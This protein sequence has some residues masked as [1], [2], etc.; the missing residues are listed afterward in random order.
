MH[1][2]GNGL[3]VD[4]VANPTIAENRDRPDGRGLFLMRNYM[5]LVEHN[6]HG[7]IVTLV[8]FRTGE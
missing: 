7:N 4:Q 2:K 5:D 8:K 1:G 3:A 6:S